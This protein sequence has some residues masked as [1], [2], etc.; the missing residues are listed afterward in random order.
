MYL[1]KKSCT[2]ISDALFKREA[3]SPPRLIMTLLVKN[4]AALLEGN[5]LFHKAMGVDAFIITD[6]NSTDSTPDI[7]QKYVDKGWV[8]ESIKEHGTDY[9]QKKWVDRMIMKARYSHSAD[10]VIN[11][12]ADEMWYSPVGNLKAEMRGDKSVL[13]CRV[14][15][16]YPT[17]DC[18]LWQRREAVRPLAQ[19]VEYDLSPYNIFTKYSYK[20]AHSVI[21]YIKI[22]MGNHKVTML[23]KRQ[24]DSE[25]VIF[26]YNILS[27][28]QFVAKMENGGRQMEQHP[29]KSVGV[30]WRYFYKLYKAGMLE[31]EYNRVIGVKYYDEFCQRG[32]I[33]DDPRPADVFKSVDFGTEI[34][35]KQ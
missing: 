22:S 23:P 12:D 24:R 29:K 3:K 25:I 2:A 34:D 8:V 9:R 31:E 20:V 17:P 4:E 1:L 14:V 28:K 33:Y 10:W 30:H 16:M 5:I 32:Y 11:A 19:G 21:G 18:E 27:G 15:N 7:I 6:N 35:K 26:H 13:R